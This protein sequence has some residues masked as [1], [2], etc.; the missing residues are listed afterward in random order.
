MSH[1]RGRRHKLPRYM[2]CTTPAEAA[3]EFR[4]VYQSDRLVKV[5]QV[6]SFG[7]MIPTITGV[8][9]ISLS[10]GGWDK[11]QKE[12]AGRPAMETGLSDCLLRFAGAG[13]PEIN[14][15]A[16]LLLAYKADQ[17]GFL[18]GRNL[19]AWQWP[20]IDATIRYTLTPRRHRRKRTSR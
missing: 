17:A 15:L 1:G 3:R 2:R 13:F 4:K 8:S 7:T 5:E 14:Q 16:E 9:S 11:M 20:I 6:L 12:L 18:L 10:H 19:T